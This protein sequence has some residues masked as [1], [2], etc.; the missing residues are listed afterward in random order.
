V[1][2][3]GIKVSAAFRIQPSLFECVAPACAAGI[4][5]MKSLIAKV[6]SH[7]MQV[8]IDERSLVRA[9]RSADVVYAIDDIT[10]CLP[11]NWALTGLPS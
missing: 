3:V 11:G 2:A 10:K 9:H 5:F 1:K 6:N 7:V 8:G 4:Y